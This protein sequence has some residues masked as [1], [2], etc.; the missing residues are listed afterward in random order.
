MPPM[1]TRS[2]VQSRTPLRRSGSTHEPPDVRRAQLLSAAI[3]CFSENGYLAT[4]MDLVAREAGLSKGSL[5]RFFESKDELLVAILDDWEHQLF[6]ALA[7]EPPG[8][9]FET[10]RTFVMESAKLASS[11]TTSTLVWVEFARHGPSKQRIGDMQERTRKYLIALIRRGVQEGSIGPVSPAG[12][13]DAVMSLMEGALVL[14]FVRE[15]FSLM[16][17]FRGMWREFEKSLSPEVAAPTTR[18]ASR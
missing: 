6:T 18:R 10:L 17:R 5:Y 8:N 7:A 14:A 4:T 15:D 11:Y 1:A 2:N 12:A 3:R 9:A 16:R 13:T